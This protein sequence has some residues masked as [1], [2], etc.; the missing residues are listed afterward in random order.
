MKAVIFDF[1]GTLFF[2]THLHVETWKR[3]VKEKFNEDL[4]D[5]GFHRKIYGRDNH[6]ILKES[7]GLTSFDE[8]HE[9]SELKEQWYRDLCDTLDI[10]LVDGS[11]EFFDYLKE[12]NILFTIA[13][14]ACE[15]NV[16]YYFDVFHLGQWFDKD[17][18]IFD[19][20][21]IPGK[22]NPT[23]FL[24][25]IDKLGV[26]S[27]DCIIFEDSKAGVEAAYKA[28][29]SKVYLIN[30]NKVSDLKVDGIFKDYYEVL[31]FMKK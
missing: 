3:F 22:P 23:V 4:D 2:D 14:G 30:E 27:E 31:E 12:N 7:Y 26:K 18:I 8:I 11:C 24:M 19:N 13:T 6:M 25:A 15:S 5:D 16:D 29:V 20:G 1:N 28:G 9:L 21:L 17:K 10:S